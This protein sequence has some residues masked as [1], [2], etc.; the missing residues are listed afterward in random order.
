MRGFRYEFQEQTPA[1]PHIHALLTTIEDPFSED[2]RRRICCSKES[3]LGSIRCKDSLTYDDRQNLGELFQRYQS[4]SCQ[5]A[6]E[7]CHKQTDEMGLSICRVPRYP[8]SHDFS[9]KSIPMNLS[10]ETLQLMHELEL[11]EINET[12]CSFQPI[13]DLKCGKHHYPAN[14][15]EHISPTNADFF[16]FGFSQA[17]MSKI[18]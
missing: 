9:Y 5:K 11:A 12:T 15:N 17:S 3:F 2:V 14:S 1:F 10:F 4:H 18:L 13:V 8:P 7:R 16:R 6:Q